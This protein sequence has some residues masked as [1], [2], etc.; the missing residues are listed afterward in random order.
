[1]ELEQAL[2]SGIEQRGVWSEEAVLLAYATKAAKLPKV[3]LAG[4]DSSDEALLIGSGWIFNWGRS[5]DELLADRLDELLGGVNATYAG[6]GA[7]LTHAF[8]DANVGLP[9]MCTR[10]DIGRR[11]RYSGRKCAHDVDRLNDS[12]RCNGVA[13]TIKME[14]TLRDVPALKQHNA[15]HHGLAAF[16]D[17][18]PEGYTD[19]ILETRIRFLFGGKHGAAYK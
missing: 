14:S 13:L 10:E 7:L 9:Q 2:N 19:D 6:L 8:S 16:G 18:A 1:M 4:S 3:T 12:L 15:E 17:L 11:R 5:K